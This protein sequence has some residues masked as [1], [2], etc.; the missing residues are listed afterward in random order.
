M[1]QKSNCFARRFLIAKKK[2][3]YL[4]SHC[5]FIALQQGDSL[6]Q[7]V[8]GLGVTLALGLVGGVAV[9]LKRQLK[10]AIDTFVA[11]SE[12]PVDPSA[13]ADQQDPATAEAQAAVPD[14]LPTVGVVFGVARKEAP[15]ANTNPFL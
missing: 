13:P 9:A 5:F 15:R 8:V 2:R 12:V 10:R 6:W 7:A 3:L 1:L 11:K 4:F 14:Q